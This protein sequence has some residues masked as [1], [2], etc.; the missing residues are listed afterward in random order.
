M[1]DSSHVL[2]EVQRVADRVALIRGGRLE[3]VDAVGAAPAGPERR[4][5]P[6]FASTPP[7]GAFTDVP[8]VNALERRGPVDRLTLEGSVDPL[9][10]ALARFE[11][12]A[13]DS[14]EPDLEDVFLDLSDD[15]RMHDGVFAKSFRDL[16]RSFAGWSRGLA[17]YAR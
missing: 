14:H 16:R 4:L 6:P 17:G 10:K 1:F 2:A 12:H 9:L 7:A 13:L 3:I 11:V 15:R 5:E 8:G